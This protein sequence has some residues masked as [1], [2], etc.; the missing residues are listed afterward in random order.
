MK[1]DYEKPIIEIVEFEF[2]IQ[3]NG[4]SGAERVHDVGDWF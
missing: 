1:K 2:D 4:G 3:T